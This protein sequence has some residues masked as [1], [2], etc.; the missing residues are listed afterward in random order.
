MAASDSDE[1]APDLE[2]GDT[3]L[4]GGSETALDEWTATRSSS[5]SDS[6]SDG[7]VEGDV[8]AP[9]RKKQKKTTR[10]ASYKV[11]VLHILWYLTNFGTSYY[12]HLG[13]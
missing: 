4:L 3:P 2:G 11:L 10:E 8:E 5:D 13:L 7:D 6:Q 12:I 1:S 9:K